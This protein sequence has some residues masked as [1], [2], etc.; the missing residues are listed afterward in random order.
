MKNLGRIRKSKKL[1]QTTLAEMVQCNQATISKIENGGNYTY[2]LATRIAAALGVSPV[3]LIG[4]SDLEQRYLAALR[5]ASPAKQRAV[6]LLLEGD[7]G[8]L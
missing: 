3:E 4:A 6:L 8:L 2:E 5:N 1:S 7:D